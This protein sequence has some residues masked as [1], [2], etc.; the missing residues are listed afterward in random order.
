MMPSRE[1]KVSPAPPHDVVE[2]L[3]LL[4]SRLGVT[5]GFPSEVLAESEN[6]RKD[7]PDFPRHVDRTSVEFVTVDPASSKDLDQ[8]VRVER[9]GSGYRVYYAIAD[10]AA[11]VRPGSA[12]EAEAKRRGETL[13]APGA[14]VPLYPDS[15]SEGVGSLLADGRP[16]PVVLWTHDLA[17]DGV[18]TGV[19]VERALVRSHAQLSYEEVQA[20]ANAGRVHPSVALLSVVGELRQRLEAERG[21][22]SLNLPS[23]EII[24]E[25]GTWLTRFRSPLP[26]ERHNAQV[27][28]LTGM[29]AAELMVG[30]AVGILRT[31]PAAAPEA[32]DRLRLSAGALGVDWPVTQPY[33][34]FVRG[35]EPG[36]PAELAVLA[37]CTSL[38]RGAGY[39]SFD[40]SLPG[41]DLGHAALAARYTHV[42]A[43][44]RRLVDRFASETCVS[45]GLG[46]SV[47]GWVR[48]NLAGL[49]E[50]MA[51]SNR[52][53]RAWEHAVVDLAEA[54]VLQARV[55]EVF[56]AVLI[57][58]NPRSG[59]GTFQIA[60][61]AVEAKLSAEGREPGRA[62][63]VRLEEVD[64]SEGRTVFS[65]AA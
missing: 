33:P 57:D 2:G 59:M 28:L 25:N 51:A 5:V 43:P 42:T 37:R 22:V 53:A 6:L 46:E 38:F 13:Y 30:A 39:R 50:L 45:I 10:V 40:G 56:D 16:R 14:R 36:E 18:S 4:R 21:G 32:I 15:F 63:R 55:G 9:N 1:L 52:R 61:P 7:P 65:H 58:V 3:D 19:G 35:L 24:A 20:D 44:L 49:P 48:E 27:S 64:L 8:A 62:V 12:L 41:D 34:D 17:A 26:V 47:P 54:L 23:Q 31:L 29:A 11:W 60:A